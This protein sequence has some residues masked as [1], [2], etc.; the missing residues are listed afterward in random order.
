MWNLGPWPLDGLCILHLR[1][2][3]GWFFLATLILRSQW[4]CHVVN[5]A[6][7]HR[8]Q[9]IREL[10]VQRVWLNGQYH[11]VTDCTWE[12]KGTRHQRSTHLRN[13]KKKKNP[14][15]G[16][17]WRRDKSG[18]RNQKF[19]PKRGVSLWGRKVVNGVRQCLK[20]RNKLWSGD[21]VTSLSGPWQKKFLWLCECVSQVHW[22][23]EWWE[24]GKQ[25]QVQVVFP[26]ERHE[27]PM[28]SKGDF[29]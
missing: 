16:G 25:R 27:G 4:D 15:R 21:L 9:E 19:W 14:W 17:L 22:T 10:S 8:R 3:R 1:N 18:R 7:E 11:P 28:E 23:E 26:S 20:R 13:G 29:V 12:G 2:N 24:V 6:Q 5:K